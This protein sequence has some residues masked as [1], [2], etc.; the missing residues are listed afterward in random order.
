MRVSLISTRRRSRDLFFLSLGLV[1][2]GVDQLTK[3]FIR[4]YMEVGESIPEDGIV[5][6]T[7]IRNTGSAFGLLSNQTLFLTI[8]AAIGICIIGYFFI[9]EAGFSRIL[10]LSLALQLGGALGN[11]IDRIIFGY[12]IDFVDLR[13]WPIFNV[14]DSSITI[15]FLLLGWVLLM[16]K[17]KKG[18]AKDASKP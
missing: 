12:V 10:S 1:V 8:A 14:A 17:G 2:L 16:G 9:K 5:R 7:Y 3:F 11:I 15:G 6:L 13:V 18:R 4:T